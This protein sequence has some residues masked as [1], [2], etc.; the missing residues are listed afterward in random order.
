MHVPVH[1]PQVDLGKGY[2]FKVMRAIGRATRKSRRRQQTCRHCNKAGLHAAYTSFPSW[3]RIFVL[4][5][6]CYVMLKLGWSDRLSLFVPDR[7]HARVPH[8]H[9]RFL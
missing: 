2:M 7:S 9:M 6:L 3:E 5:S 4:R 1:V 8:V